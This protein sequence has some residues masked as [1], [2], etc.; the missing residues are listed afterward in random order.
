MLSCDASERA[1]I[2]LSST[3]KDLGANHFFM[4]EYNVHWRLTLFMR[5]VQAANLVADD[6]LAELDKLLCKTVR[7]FMAQKRLNVAKEL[8]A[9][10]E[11]KEKD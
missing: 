3:Y 10:I 6:N 1:Q 7:E 4:R 8:K 2:R 9:Y 11:K 5:H